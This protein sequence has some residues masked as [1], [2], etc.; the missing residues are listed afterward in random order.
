M[1]KYKMPYRYDVHWGFIDNQVELSPEDYLYCND[2]SDLYDA[3]YDD[4]YDSFSTG[5]LEIDQADMDYSIPQEFI[6]EWK[7]LKGYEI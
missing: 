4:I 2:V 5:D 6:D 7:V 3:I 1:S